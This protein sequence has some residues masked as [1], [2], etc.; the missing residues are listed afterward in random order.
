MEK[1]HF[2]KK[3]ESDRILRELFN[4]DELPVRLGGNK[5]EAIPPSSELD[6][7]LHHNLPTEAMRLLLSRW[8]IS[9][10]CDLA[11]V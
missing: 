1:V 8:L 3:E 11:R 2:L 4:P 10:G 6:K 9:Y 5:V 7:V